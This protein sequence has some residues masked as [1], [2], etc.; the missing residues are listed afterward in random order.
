MRIEYELWEGSSL[1]DIIGGTNGRLLDDLHI[2]FVDYNLLLF[3]RL[4]RHRVWF[5]RC[6]KPE[7]R[8]RKAS[9]AAKL[10]A[11]VAARR[12]ASFEVFFAPFILSSQ[13]LCGASE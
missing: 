10:A 13:V 2:L 5:S 12:A 4:G 8:A 9:S 3:I 7:P 11:D 6:C 1:L